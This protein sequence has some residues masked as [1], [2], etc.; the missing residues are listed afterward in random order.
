MQGKTPVENR[1]CGRRPVYSGS[2]ARQSPGEPWRRPR[3][4]Q[5]LALPRS[6]RRQGLRLKI[7]DEEK[8]RTVLTARSSDDGFETDHVVTKDENDE[9]ENVTDEHDGETEVMGQT[10]VFPSAVVASLEDLHRSGMAKVGSKTT[11]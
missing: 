9:K 5:V 2:G 7:L 1:C 4:S 6:G 11:W 10:T 3:R 8:M